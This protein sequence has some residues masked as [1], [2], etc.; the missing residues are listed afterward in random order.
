MDVPVNSKHLD[1]CINRL[2]KV[3]ME[4][5]FD[6]FMSDITKHTYTRGG[7]MRSASNTQLCDMIVS[8]WNDIEP[9]TILNSFKVCGQ[10][11]GV[12]VADILS[13]RDGKTCASGRAQLESLWHLDGDSIDMNLLRIKYPEDILE[14]DEV[15]GDTD[16]EVYVNS[17]DPII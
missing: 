17:Q 6:D 4:D 8:A 15:H 7:N 11:P 14:V 12:E 16:Y 5:L 2:F 13:F 3:K 1:V 10:L 9:G